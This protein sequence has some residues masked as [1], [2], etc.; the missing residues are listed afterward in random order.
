LRGTFVL[1]EKSSALLRFTFAFFL[2]LYFMQYKSATQQKPNAYSAAGL[3][4][5][6]IFTF[7]IVC[8]GKTKYM[9]QKAMV[10]FVY[11]ITPL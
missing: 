1:L 9:L 5:K 8:C 3:P 7:Y 10:N 4:P 11:P 6:K 2:L